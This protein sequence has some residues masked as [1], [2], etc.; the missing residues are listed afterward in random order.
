MKTVFMQKLARCPYCGV[1]PLEGEGDDWSYAGCDF[2]FDDTETRSIAFREVRCHH[3]NCGKKWREVYPLAVIQ[4][5][6]D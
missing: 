5:L 4:L 2:G 6:D 3:Q 1:P